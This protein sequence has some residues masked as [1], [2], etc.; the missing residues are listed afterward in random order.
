[1]RAP[2]G[3]DAVE[4]VSA[5]LARVPWEWEAEVLLALP[6]KDARERLGATMAE[7]EPR[8]AGTLL[9]IRAGSLAWLA[10]LLAGLDCEFTVLRPDELRESV[11]EL[12]ERLT[13]AVS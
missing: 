6:P 8:G 4:H 2:A 3:F 13:S 12:G 5:A 10:R 9:R 7:L 11:R 1:V